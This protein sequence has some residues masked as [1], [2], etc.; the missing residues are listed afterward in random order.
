MPSADRL[1]FGY[2]LIE[3]LVV[4]ALMGLLMG[5]TTPRL[6]QM[7]DSVT[8]SL[9]RD[10]IL[11]QLES[12]PFAVYQRGEAFSLISLS[13]D[14]QPH[15]LTSPF[16]LPKGWELNERATSDIVYNALGFCTGGEALFVRDDRE[17]K[18]EL[19][20]PMCQPKVL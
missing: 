12:L 15:P 18:V 7:Y 2:T 6:I 8:F 14:G 13:G 19:K 4:L 9:E 20:A 3:L 1:C 17:L 10:E 5:V 11:Y 16:E